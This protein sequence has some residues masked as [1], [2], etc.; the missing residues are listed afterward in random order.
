[1]VAFQD[2]SL[3]DKRSQIKT[4]KSHAAQANNEDFIASALAEKIF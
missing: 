1:M 2:R 3:H 4:K